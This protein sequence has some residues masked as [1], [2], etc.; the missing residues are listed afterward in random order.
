VRSKEGTQRIEV[1]PSDDFTILRDKVRTWLFVSA[2]NTS[3]FGRCRLT[4]TFFFL[5]VGQIAKELKINDP[6]TIAI[7]DWPTPGVLLIDS[8]AGRTLQDLNVK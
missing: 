7:T 6:S 2:T 5:C 1:N 8:F 4:K 3:R